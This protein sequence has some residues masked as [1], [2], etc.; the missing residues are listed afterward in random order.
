MSI[1][2]AS[3]NSPKSI[4]EYKDL[5][6]NINYNGDANKVKET[7][8]VFIKGACDA[9]DEI[10]ADGVVTN[11][12]A[13]QISSWI[14]IISTLKTNLLNRPLMKEVV[15]KLQE[16]REILLD[17]KDLAAPQTYEPTETDSQQCIEQDTPSKENI[18]HEEWIKKNFGAVP[19]VHK[20]A[21]E[22]GDVEIEAKIKEDPVSDTKVKAA[23]QKKYTKEDYIKHLITIGYSKEEAEKIAKENKIS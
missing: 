8:S 20:Y 7:I 5:A 12:E 3:N 22:E 16:L 6:K 21:G 19:D 13:K 14:S 1:D 10:S 4:D 15:N 18:T 11:D 17:L 2:G 9:A 23:H